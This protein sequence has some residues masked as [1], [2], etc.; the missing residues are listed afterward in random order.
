V[1]SQLNQGTLTP[2]ADLTDHHREQRAIF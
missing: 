1:F 2:T